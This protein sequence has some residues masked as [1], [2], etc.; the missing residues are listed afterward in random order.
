MS[1]SESRRC[2]QKNDM[3]KFFYGIVAA[4]I[5]PLAFVLSGCGGDDPEPVIPDVPAVS[6]TPDNPH[7][8]NQDG[9]NTGND[10]NPER[11]PVLAQAMEYVMKVNGVPYYS[12]IKKDGKLSSYGSTWFYGMGITYREG[13]NLCVELYYE[14]DFDKYEA[15]GLSFGAFCDRFVDWT[16]D[17]NFGSLDPTIARKGD[18][19]AITNADKGIDHHYCEPPEVCRYGYDF[20][21]MD[22][23]DIAFESYDAES[24]ILI[25][26]FTNVRLHY[27]GGGG[28]H[29][30]GY[31]PPKMITMDG[32]V[33][34]KNKGSY[35]N[36][37]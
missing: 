6:P 31:D 11:D 25:L 17:F 4:M 22:D 15:E 27:N 5:V 29:V 9:E 16:F 24:K 13:L 35:A 36:K 1:A 28:F 12:W 20:D 8:D 30:P 10:P 21:D 23:I 7:E 33:A 26:R 32:L 14:C 19:V 18:R 2:N 3:K 34:V 37:D